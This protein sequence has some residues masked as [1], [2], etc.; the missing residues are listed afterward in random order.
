MKRRLEIL[1]SKDDVDLTPMIDIVFLLLI[2]FMVTTTLIKQEA[3]LGIQLPTPNVLQKE[4]LDLPDEHLVII[5]AIGQVLLNDQPYDEPNNHDLPQLTNT[6][7][8]LKQSSDLA[9]V[10]TLVTIEV[11]DEARHERVIDVLNSCAVAE[12]K[13]VSFGM[14]Q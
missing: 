13:M 14:G 2:Y 6:L 11:E 12:I 1:Q 9:G 7:T 3:D 4:P 5:Q 10:K 8:V